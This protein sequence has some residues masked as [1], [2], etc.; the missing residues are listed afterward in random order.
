MGNTASVRGEI[1]VR[2]R[3][4]TAAEPLVLMLGPLPCCTPCSGRSLQGI[5]TAAE[6]FLFY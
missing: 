4:T 1:A 2:V 6:R 5:V 3:L